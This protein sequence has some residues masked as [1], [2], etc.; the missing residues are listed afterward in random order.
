[1]RMVAAVGIIGNNDLAAIEKGLTQIRDEVRAGRFP[2]S[3]QHEDVHFNIERRLT[4]LVGEPGKRLHT[5][6]SRNDQ[7]AT[8]VRLYLRAA[9][10]QALATI[11]SVQ[12]ALL[13][14]A[15]EHAE[16]LMPGYTHMQVARTVSYG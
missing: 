8:D 11:K 13:D 7:V 1:G 16:T 5:A 2:L 15:D 6:R 12:R 4:E 3:E 14:L 9:I 10:D